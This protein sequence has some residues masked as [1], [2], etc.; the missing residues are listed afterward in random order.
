MMLFGLIPFLPVYERLDNDGIF[1]EDGATL[2]IDGVRYQ[3]MPETKWDVG[4]PSAI[5]GYAGSWAFPVSIVTND[6]D[7]NFLYL[8]DLSLIASF[9]MLLYRTGLPEPS[10]DSIDRLYWSDYVIGNWTYKGEYKDN[11]YR[12]IDQNITSN[13][14]EDKA[15]IKELFDVWDSG[16][17]TS[18]ITSLGEFE[19]DITCYSDAVP[20][21]SYTF[22]IESSGGNLVFGTYEEGY[23]EIPL[24][25]LEK[26]AG[27]KI[28]VDRILP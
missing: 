26:I 7:R 16:S 8:S 12:N 14:I 23:T 22:E 27:Y 21:A 24:E 20:G 2:L 25:L 10:A 5:I 18:D 17:K 9:H 19:M 6:P 15:I 11:D 28:N 3:T 13:N 4:T 1:D